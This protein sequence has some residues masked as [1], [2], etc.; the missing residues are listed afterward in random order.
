M[1]YIPKGSYIARLCNQP[2]NATRYENALITT[3]LKSI[4]VDSYI[5]SPYF[6]TT[7]LSSRVEWIIEIEPI[8]SSNEGILLEGNQ[9]CIA[10]E[11]FKVTK[12]WKLLSRNVCCLRAGF[13]ASNSRS[14]L[15]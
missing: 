1:F 5:Q 15:M 2:A 11:S 14:Q 13:I 10:K 9:I 7:Q 8:S 3:P 4:N 12:S 6:S